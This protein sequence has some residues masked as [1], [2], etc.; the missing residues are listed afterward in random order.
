MASTQLLSDILAGGMFHVEHFAANPW[1]AEASPENGPL[2]ILLFVLFGGITAGAGFSVAIAKN[3]VRAAVGL[4]FALGGMSG[5]YLLLSA[6]FIAAVQL[7]VYVGGTLILIVFGVMLTSKSP[8]TTYAPKRWE[9]VWAVIV[10]LLVG[11]PVMAILVSTFNK[12]SP[13]EH[14]ATSAPIATTTIAATAPSSDAAIG[15]LGQ[16]YP[17]K[18][19]GRALLD[20]AGFLVPFE[21]VSVLLLAVM[22]GAAYLAKGRRAKAGGA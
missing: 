16:E 5:L 15:T 22:I 17:M 18:E 3:I 2:P 4:L 11:V 14:A 10:A 20:P 9:V 6:E 7:V 12:I 8:R 21:L 19:M 1:I 13:A